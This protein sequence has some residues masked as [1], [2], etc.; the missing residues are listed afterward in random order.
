M[1]VHKDVLDAAKKAYFDS[2]G[3]FD[4]RMDAAIEAAFQ[5]HFNLPTSQVD[6]NT[7]ILV[8]ESCE[9]SESLRRVCIYLP[10]ILR[11]IINLRATTEQGFISL[12]AKPVMCSKCG[13]PQHT[14][15]C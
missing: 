7:G 5:S 11:A 12:Q 6:I 4:N 10:D 3:P 8:K 2:L 13:H 15:I 14:G 1:P 9:Q